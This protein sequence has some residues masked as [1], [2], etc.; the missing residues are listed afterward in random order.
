MTEAEYWDL[1]ELV[2]TEIDQAIAVSSVY[3][4]INGAI[5]VDDLRPVLDRERLF[6]RTQLHSLQTTLFITMARIFDTAPDAYS[7]H[8]VIRGAIANTAFFSPESLRLRRLKEPPGNQP[9]L[10]DD[11]IARAWI[12]E[13]R[14]FGELRKPLAERTELFRAIYQPIRNQIFAH[15]LADT[16]TEWTLFEKTHTAHIDG[17]LAFLKKLIDLI[18][19]AFQNGTEPKLGESSHG[20]YNQAFKDSTMNV[21]AT[22]AS[23]EED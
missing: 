11:L 21:L 17:M 22:L 13:A 12:P 10:R 23:A 19:D 16:K 3:D 15:R 2:S 8:A 5:R 4:S 7:I 20:A 6:W 9:S 18:R 1:C 14:I